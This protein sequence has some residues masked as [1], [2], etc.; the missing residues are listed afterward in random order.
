MHK[1]AVKLFFFI[2]TIN[3]LILIGSC[4]NDSSEPEVSAAKL[5][6]EF[7]HLIDGQSI[8]YDSLMYINEAGNK[9]LVN[10]IQYFISDVSL[11]KADGSTVVLDEWENIHYFDSDIIESF[12]YGFKDDI[13]PG[14]YNQI[15]FTF[16]IKPE[17]NQSL[18]FVNP[19]ESFMFWPENLGGGYHY[20]K[21]NG[22]WINTEN[23]L[24]PFNFHLGIGQIYYSYPDSIIDFIHND[25]VVELAGFD[26]PMTENNTTILQ[27]SMNVE[28]WF[29]MPNTYDHNFWGGDIMQNQDAMKVA[30]ENGENVFTYKLK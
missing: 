24:A 30:S 10:E 12:S 16:G 27:L 22:K 29:K 3:I 21:L 14:E 4:N 7:Q 2:T 28:N 5:K 11:H 17:N 13:S 20:M 23:Q 6:I 19:P 25:F 18:M 9:Y 1:L 8:I 15:S 26:I